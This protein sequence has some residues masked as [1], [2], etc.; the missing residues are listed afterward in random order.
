MEK[1]QK[2]LQ[3][4]PQARILDIA[5]GSGQFIELITDLNDGYEEII[6]IDLSDR[7]LEIGKKHFS[8]NPR[9]HFEK[10][11]AFAMTFPEASFDI[12][13]LS[14]S[15][16]HI[17]N[18]DPAIEAMSKLLKPHGMLLFNEMICDNLDIR[19]ISHRLLHH[20]AAKID[21]ELGEVHQDTMERAAIIALL[22]E[23]SGLVIHDAWDLEYEHNPTNTPEEI[24][25]LCQVVDRQLGRIK[26]EGKVNQLKSEGEVIK[27]YITKNGFDSATQL[28]VLM[29]RLDN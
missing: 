8:G 11:D 25:S 17:T 12:V 23:H 1:L 10:M 27:E 7:G 9:I 6:G 21:R 24:A 14:N 2:F 22:S 19:Q 5:T 28:V 26:D 15:L 4:Y 29:E 18:V 20:F 3:S 13:C 16:H